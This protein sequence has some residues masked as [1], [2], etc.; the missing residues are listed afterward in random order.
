LKL[1]TWLLR[2]KK[3]GW[4]VWLGEKITEIRRD[5]RWIEREQVEGI[6]MGMG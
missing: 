2:Q 4:D 3:A 6:K 1:T 5:G